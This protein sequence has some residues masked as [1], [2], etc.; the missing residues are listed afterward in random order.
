MALDFSPVT[1]GAATP[2]SPAASAVN[3]TAAPVSA[4]P[5][6]DLLAPLPPVRAVD[7]GVLANRVTG[8]G[9]LLVVLDDDP[10]G[11]QTIADLPVLTAWSV[12]DLRWAIRQGSPACYVLTNTRSLDPDQAAA[13]NRAVV[14]SLV[15]AAR[16]EQCAFALVSRGDSTLR[17]H[18]PL[19][20]DVLHDA[21]VA[22]GEPPA[23]GLLLCPAYLD[24]GRLTVE[25]VH[26]MRT[27][28][29]MLPVG[30]S[31][32]ARDATFGYRSSNL[33]S[34]IEEKT[35]GRWRAE[36]VLSIGLDDI[37]LGGERRVAELLGALRGGRPAIV[38][39][40]SEDDLRVVALGALSA[41][42][43]G[44][45]LL[46]RTGPSFVRARAG[47]AARE[48]LTTAQLYPDGAP[49]RHGLIVVGSHVSLTTRQL[50]A[51]RRSGG[52][53]E[54]ELDV[55]ALLDPDRR[56]CHIE[57]VAGAAARGL[58][59]ADVVVRTTRQ[60]VTGAD[61]ASS[62][63][64]ARQVS[65]ALV[66]VVRAVTA[67]R[68]PRFVVAKGGITSSDVATDG[69]GI[70]RAWVRGTLLPGIVS[71]WSAVDG[72]APGVP[73]VVFAGNVGTDESL[74]RVVDVLRG[75]P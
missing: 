37:R 47:Q 29:G 11:T 15:A 27:S 10:T 55:A 2:A 20:T 36:D 45:R 28:D 13:R 75:E 65:A 60:V 26:W 67:T 44:R 62:L 34:F 21:L 61:P 18:Y 56:A 41:E 52:I 32:F 22:H 51:L 50:E 9:R 42:R 5:E 8:S 1:S 63:G 71:A 19:E 73:Y 53:T 69:L 70:R 38:N 72:A 12:D 7:P 58:D 39:A 49:T 17:G 66:Q 16:A 64:I 4:T 40:A 14:A 31:E 54:I 30:A 57:A 25:D 3:A 35:G 68:A 74:A 33:R 48:P 46:Y 43:D 6:R 59:A 24:A 23:D